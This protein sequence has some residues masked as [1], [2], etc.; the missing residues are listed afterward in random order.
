[1]QTTLTKSAV[2]A[3]T[4]LSFIGMS[5]QALA[6]EQDRSLKRHYAS[7]QEHSNNRAKPHNKRSAQIHPRSGKIH[8][9]YKRPHSGGYVHRARAPHGYGYPTHYSHEYGY[10]VRYDRSY[11]HG[12][13][14]APA[15]SYYGSAIYVAPLIGVNVHLD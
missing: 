5:S 3:I 11:T 10:R 2:I 7:K 12:Y 14:H 1:M 9:G 8:G 6:S 13:P 15:H 4:V